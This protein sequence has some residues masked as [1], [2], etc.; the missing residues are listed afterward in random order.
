MT[1]R[2]NKIDKGVL[3]TVPNSKYDEM[4]SKYRHLQGVVMDD[5]DEKN[6]LPIHV[7]LGGSEYSRIKTKPNPESDNSLNQ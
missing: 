5:T 1:T 2:I 3:L 6:Q 4:I 7:I